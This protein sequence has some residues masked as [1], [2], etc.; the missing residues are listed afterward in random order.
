MDLKGEGGETIAAG[1]YS[2]RVT[3]RVDGTDLVREWEHETE[4]G[5]ETR[6]TVIARKIGG[7]RFTRQGLLVTVSLDVLLP[8]QAYAPG[9]RTLTTRV[10]LRN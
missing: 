6:R 3:Y 1:V 5:V 4:G 10:W 8:K 7:L 9:L 2:R